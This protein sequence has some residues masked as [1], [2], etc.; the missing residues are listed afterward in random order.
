MILSSMLAAR[1]LITMGPTQGAGSNPSISVNDGL[2]RKGL[3]LASHRSCQSSKSST[4]SLGIGVC[5]FVVDGI[6]ARTWTVLGIG[7]CDFVVDGIGV[8]TWTVLGIGVCGFVI[9]GI[10][11]RHLDRSGIGVCDFVIVNIG[12]QLRQLVRHRIVILDAAFTI[13][14]ELG[15]LAPP[16][17]CQ[18]LELP[19]GLFAYR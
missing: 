4:W 5:N 10:G 16:T 6:G 1:S 15:T 18:C 9:V 3:A 13:Q 8:R 2:T 11:V 17:I 7:V 14:G 12:I 19:E